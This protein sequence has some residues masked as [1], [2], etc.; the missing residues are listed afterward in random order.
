MKITLVQVPNDSVYGQYKDFDRKAIKR[1]PL[2][3]ACIASYV[4]KHDRHEVSCVDG[5]FN[6]FSIE[7]TARAVAAER[8]DVVGFTAT[9][10][11]PLPTRKLAPLR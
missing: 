10:A 1:F 9:T 2:N 5:D 3:L 7:E 6:E 4:H 11:T 8:P